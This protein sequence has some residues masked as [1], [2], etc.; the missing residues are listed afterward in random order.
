MHKKLERRKNGTYLPETTKTN[1]RTVIENAQQLTLEGALA[2]QEDTLRFAVR[3]REPAIA[4][5]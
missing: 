5:L 2:G 1:S 4:L 3:Q